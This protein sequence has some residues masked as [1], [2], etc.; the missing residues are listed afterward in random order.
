MIKAAKDFWSNRRGYGVIELMIIV[1][2]L[3]GIAFI[4]GKTFQ[5]RCDQSADTI[6]NKIDDYVTENWSKE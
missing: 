6:G 4:V 1:A 2:I 5:N 3:G